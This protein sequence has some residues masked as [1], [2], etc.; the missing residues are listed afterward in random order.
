MGEIFFPW[1]VTLCYGKCSG[2]T[3]K[4]LL[5]PFPARAIRKSFFFFQILG[6]ENL[7]FWNKSLCDYSSQAIFHY[8]A[9][10]CISSESPFKPA[11]LFMA[12]GLLFQWTVFSCVSLNTPVSIFWC[13]N[14]HC[15]LRSLMD[16]TKAIDFHFAQLFLIVRMGV[17][18][19][20]LLKCQC[21]NWNSLSSVFFYLKHC[22]LY[23][24][25]F[26]FSAFYISH[27]SI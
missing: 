18:T 15:I 16:P 4:W 26:N 10:L 19:S 3:S 22:S 5:L 21:W 2:C 13:D 9:S 17:T 7:V 20:K 1:R 27:A 14:L 6:S 25:K 24:S 23:L 12:P 11:Y 8:H